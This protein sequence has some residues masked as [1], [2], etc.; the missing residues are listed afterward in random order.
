LVFEDDPKY[1]GLVGPTIGMTRDLVAVTYPWATVGDN[2]GAGR[3]RVQGE[4]GS[5]TIEWDRIVPL[6]EAGFT[7]PVALLRDPIHGVTWL[8]ASAPWDGEGGVIYI[9]ALDVPPTM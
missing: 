9:F 6:N 8:V 1:P 4:A 2:D 7:G 5:W 3:V